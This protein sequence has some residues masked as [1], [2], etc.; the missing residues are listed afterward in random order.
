M[1]LAFCCWALVLV[2]AALGASRVYHLSEDSPNRPS[3]DIVLCLDVSSSMAD[4]DADVITSYLR[5]ISALPD[6]RVGLVMFDASAVTAFPLT[7]DHEAVRARLEQA[8]SELN[9]VTGTTYG[10]SGQSLVGDGLAACVNRFSVGE[11]RSRTVVLATDNLVSGDPVYS[12]KEAAK[13]AADKKIMVFA[14]APRQKDATATQELSDATAL[15][16]GRTLL[17]TPGQPDN[18]ADIAEALRSQQQR[19]AA[20]QGLPLV[21]EDD[22]S[23]GLW[24]IAAGLLG[25]CLLSWTTKGAA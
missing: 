21:P 7:Q 17:I 15:T 25:V 5:L 23:I 2:G 10:S 16:G 6:D 8:K 20:N 19:H 14:V 22:P 3:R 18:L 24:L 13:L 4:L 1:L 12:T 9:K 11:E